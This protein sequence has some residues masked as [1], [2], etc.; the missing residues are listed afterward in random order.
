MR[1]A[2][3][4]L[5]LGAFLAAFVAVAQVPTSSTYRIQVEDILQIKVYKEPEATW[6]GPVLPDGNIP[7]P[8]IGTIR[9]A[10]RTIEELRQEIVGEMKKVLLIKEPIVSV[11]IISIRKI[12]ASAGGA[13]TRPDIY[14][15]RPG[16]TVLDL[17]QHGGGPFFDGRSSLK[18]AFIRHKGSREVVPVDLHA[19]LIMGDM[20]QNYVIQDGDELVIPEENRNRIVVDGVVRTPTVI[21]YREPMRVLEAVNM[22]GGE[23]PYKTRMSRV[24]VIREI[25]GRPGN[26][27]SIECDLVAFK[28]KGDAKQNILLEAGDI[29]YVP[30]AGN[31]DFDKIGAVANFLFILD[32]FGLNFLGLT[33]R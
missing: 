17:L 19:M 27:V 1:A 22:A 13:I 16:E 6:Q 29:V 20:S 31:I 15:I 11:E 18:R 21:Q 24:Q 30:D 2:R 3:L 7:A 10:G 14:E 9:A 32:R 5:T 4:L 33:R 8:F 28:T 23:V 26:Y 12:R 25:T